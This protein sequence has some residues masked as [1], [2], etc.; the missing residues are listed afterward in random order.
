[1]FV[2]DSATSLV[3]KRYSMQEHIP[4][5]DP[6][7]HQPFAEHW[8]PFTECQKPLTTNYRSVVVGSRQPVIH[9]VWPGLK[10]QSE[11][12]QF[13]HSSWICV[14]VHCSSFPA[15]STVGCLS[16]FPLGHPVSLVSFIVTSNCVYLTVTW[17]HPL[18]WTLGQSSLYSLRHD[19]SPLLSF[20]IVDDIRLVCE[21]NVPI[22]SILLLPAFGSSWNRFHQPYASYNTLHLPFA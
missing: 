11:E 20:C 3:G 1:M 16:W 7:V 17:Q 10:S 6:K 18:T 8:Q 14:V 13:G 21:G 12:N 19:G 15:I 9:L 22:S 4:P 5:V 2:G